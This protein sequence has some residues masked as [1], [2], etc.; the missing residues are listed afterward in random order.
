MWV[1]WFSPPPPT[2]PPPQ[3]VF[4]PG[5]GPAHCS[6]DK[7]PPSTAEQSRWWYQLL[8]KWLLITAPTQGVDLPIKSFPLPEGAQWPGPLSSRVDR[9][10]AAQGALPSSCSSQSLTKGH[11]EEPRPALIRQDLS[12]H[13][14]P[15][16]VSIRRLLNKTQETGTRTSNNNILLFVLLLLLHCL[17]PYCGP[18]PHCTLQRTR[19]AILA[20]QNC[21]NKRL[22]ECSLP[23]KSNHTH[24]QKT[25]SSPVT[26]KFYHTTSFAMQVKQYTISERDRGQQE[27]NTPTQTSLQTYRASGWIW[28]FVLS[29]TAAAVAWPLHRTGTLSW[30]LLF[31]TG[32]KITAHW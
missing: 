14:L 9:A 5:A 32:G 31:T 10:E 16:G 1:V 20:P 24:T 17:R 13:S 26:A 21:E 23:D 12:F 11:W 19:Q 15:P 29:V 28:G 27:R 2:P 4:Y 30:L 6:T 7:V 22:G 18:L 8:Q 25:R 3:W